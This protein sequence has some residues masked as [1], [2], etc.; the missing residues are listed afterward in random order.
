MATRY[1]TVLFD[2][3]GVL[4][5]SMGNHAIAWCKSM[6]AF[7]YN[8]TEEDAFACEGMRGVETIRLIAKREKGTE[9]SEEEASKMYAL[10]SEYYAQFPPASLIP[11]VKAL[12]RMLCSHGIT[13]GVVT[14][15]GQ[16]SLLNRIL[17]DFDGLVSPDVIVTANDIEHGKPAPDPYLMGMQ[18]A[19]TKPEETIVVENAPLG[20]RASKAAQC[21]TIAVNTGPLPDSQLLDAGADILFHNME[22]VKE[23]IEN[24]I[25]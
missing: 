19:G 11:G 5:D 9:V 13:I 3:D 25:K 12:H 8:M 1:K 10:K 7:G 18:K 20:I 24:K 2:M 23:W 6:N 4:Y 15:S 17:R 14:G 21:F 22:E 16:P